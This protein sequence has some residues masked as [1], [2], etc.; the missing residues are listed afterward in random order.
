MRKK[1]VTG[2]GVFLRKFINEKGLLDVREVD[3]WE[4]ILMGPDFKNLRHFR[5]SYFLRRLNSLTTLDE[6]KLKALGEYFTF[7][8]MIQGTKIREDKFYN[9]HYY[10][11]QGF[12][13]SEEEIKKNII[14]SCSWTTEEF[15][16]RSRFWSE[17]IQS[18]TINNLQSWSDEIDYK[19]Y[20]VE[21]D[22]RNTVSGILRSYNHE[23]YN[24]GIDF[25]NILHKKV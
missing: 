3:L 20:W 16:K 8:E 2:T 10:L 21:V 17:K 12:T 24:E 22:K 25:L 6:N 23:F 19:D 9:V 15:Y 18:Y 13:I 1:S 4:K 5:V 11:S 14:F 7:I